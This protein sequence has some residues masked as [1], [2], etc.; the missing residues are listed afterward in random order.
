VQ[1]NHRREQSA[2]ATA[3]RYS[4]NDH[5]GA[6]DDFRRIESCERADQDQEYQI[7]GSGRKIQQADP[8][9]ILKRLVSPSPDTA[10][11]QTS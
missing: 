5:W 3:N 9:D 2:N 6:Y 11:R 7:L 10:P 1:K 4:K 8:N